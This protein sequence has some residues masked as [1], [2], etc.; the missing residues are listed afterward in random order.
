MIQIEKRYFI[1]GLTL[2]LITLSFAEGEK[3][4]EMDKP[5]SVL[6]FKMERKTK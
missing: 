5:A 4:G 2:F 6:F 1:H 3:G